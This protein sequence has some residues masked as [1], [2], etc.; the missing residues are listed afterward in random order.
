MIEFELL[1]SA[2]THAHLGAIPA[3]LS[4]DDPRPAREQFDERYGFAGGWSP[5]KGFELRDDN[6]IKYPGDPAHLPLAQVRLREEL[7]VFYASAW[8][9]IIQPDRS[10]EI[11]RLD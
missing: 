1:H 6:A 4:P 10:Y 2:M 8:V 7:I 9:A 5:M 11:A 3:F